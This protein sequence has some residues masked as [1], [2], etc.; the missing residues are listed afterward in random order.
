MRLYKKLIALCLVL[1]FAITLSSCSS[2]NTPDK[3]DTGN[4]E[5]KVMKSTDGKIEITVPKSWNEENLNNDVAILQVA[6]FSKEQYL[7]IITESTED[8]AVDAAPSDYLELVL[9]NI[10]TVS[11][12][13]I[14]SEQKDIKINGLDATQCEVSAE[15]EKIKIKYLITVIKSKDQFIQVLA[16]SLSSK[17]AESKPAL[18]SATNS[19]KV[20]Q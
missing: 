17:Y 8:F 19:I 9:E 2:V 13:P 11:V 15:I 4:N 12:N 7:L 10:K 1:A 5:T 14:I 3:A 16:W 18:E 20:V 6:D